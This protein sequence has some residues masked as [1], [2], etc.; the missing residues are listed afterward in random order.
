MP[1][2]ARARR[3]SAPT[4]SW[5]EITKPSTVGSS[6]RSTM[7]SSK[8]TTVVPS[9]RSSPTRMVTGWAAVAPSA[10]WPSGGHD[11][12]AVGLGDDVGEWP[13]LDELGIVA[14]Q[15]GDGARGGLEEPGGGHE[16]DHGA[17]VVHQRPEACLTA[18]GQL[19]APALG[20]VTQAQ[21]DEALPGQRERGADDLDQAPAR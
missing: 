7:L 8:G 18:A 14:Q 13:H 4:A 19:E 16:H 10:A 5:A 1:R 20:Q 2:S 12:P 17:D 11:L 15:P 3:P 21:E 9:W 6:I